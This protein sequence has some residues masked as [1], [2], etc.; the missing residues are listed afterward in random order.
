[1][2]HSTTN[3]RPTDLAVIG[4]SGRFPGAP[5]LDTFWHNLCQGQETIT[6]FTD[7]ELAQAGIPADLLHHPR[8]V[9]AKAVL[10]QIELF[11]ANFFGFSPRECATPPFFGNSLA[12][13]GTRRLWQ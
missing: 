12:R 11:D 1:M 4:L 8:Y 5:D 7:E 13:P 6:F 9:K 2:N 3:T 10:E